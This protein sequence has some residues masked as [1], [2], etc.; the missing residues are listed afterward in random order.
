ML[1]PLTVT[2]IAAALAAACVFT[3]DTGL[4]RVLTVAA[5]LTAVAGATLARVWD[6]SAGREVAELTTLRTRDE[7]R[8]DERIA[9]VETDLEEAREIRGRLEKKLR[10]KRAELARLR[11]SHADLLRRYADAESERVRELEARRRLRTADSPAAAPLALG[12]GVSAIRPGAY[13]KAADALRN[14]SRN[15]A[16]QQAQLTVENA[17]RRD[18]AASDEPQGKHA[19]DTVGSRALP[20]REHRLTPAGTA[21]AVLPYA[22][23]RGG[24]HQPHRAVGG[25]D[26]FGT[27]KP[28]VPALPAARPATETGRPAAE[29]EQAPD[30]SSGIIDLTAHDDTEQL[31]LRQLRAQA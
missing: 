20:V 3:G 19:A 24:A 18:T 5:A 7:W 29:H 23:Q 8:A 17:R 16:R 4:L 28:A 14:L 1:P 11:T 21:A 15:A 27:Q 30:A 26:F 12:T 10:A 31:D 13:L 6:R 2:G 22:Q 9:E 25:F